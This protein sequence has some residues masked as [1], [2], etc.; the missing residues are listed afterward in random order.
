[1]NKLIEEDVIGTG[2]EMEI[3]EYSGAAVDGAV[4]CGHERVD[5]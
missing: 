1:M 4:R 3:A 5:R 2:I